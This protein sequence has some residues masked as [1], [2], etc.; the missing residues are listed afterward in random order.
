MAPRKSLS[1]KKIV[2]SDD[3]TDSGAPAQ[4]D[5]AF[6][7]SDLTPPPPASQE[8]AAAKITAKATSKG[9]KDAR[10]PSQ[11]TI[12]DLVVVQ[13]VAGNSKTAPEKGRTRG[14]GRKSESASTSATPSERPTPTPGEAEPESSKPIKLKLSVAKSSTSR[15]ATPKAGSDKS[16]LKSKPASGK[17]ANDK[18]VQ[19]RAAP[20]DRDAGLIDDDD[21]Q[22]SENEN[23]TKKV[24]L[25]VK[26][27]EASSSRSPSKRA[28]AEDT[29]EELVKPERKKAKGKAAVKGEG[30]PDD[31]GEQ[32]VVQPRK[33]ESA[34]VRDS[35]VPEKKSGGAVTGPVVAK[36]PD[37]QEIAAS[38]SSPPRK[39]IQSSPMREPKPLSKAKKPRPSEPVDVAEKKTGVAKVKTEDA[40]PARSKSSPQL[41]AQAEGSVRKAPP[42]KPV[43]KPNGTG[44]PG[45]PAKPSGLGMGLLGNT[46]AL[47]QGGGTPKT[48]DT[49]KDTPG[50]RDAPKAQQKGGWGHGWVL[51]AEEQR[52]YDSSRPQREAERARRAAWK[53]DPVNLQE[54]KEALRVDSMQPRA[55]HVEG[56]MGI[57]TAGKP[58]EMMRTLLGW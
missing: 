51:T 8:V 18:P 52:Q 11:E 58:S 13:P 46:L 55:I 27:V 31:I 35:S 6:S 17:P 54:A 26:N 2:Q 32:M 23:L 28:I 45:Q 24:K 22:E 44:T 3:E 21:K 15:E 10:T 43:P 14:K 7:D 36:S 33:E 53:K 49:K 56:A 42:K 12:G 4:Q 39:G 37:S 48:K 57:Q 1:R 19:K 38:A 34:S 40:V 9:K 20:V 29:T 30:S 47:L 41:N 50:K 16:A 25:S 5:D